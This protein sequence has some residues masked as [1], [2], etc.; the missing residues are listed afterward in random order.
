MIAGSRPTVADSRIATNLIGKIY[1]IDLNK[2]G[3]HPGA[4]PTYYATNIDGDGFEDV[5]FFV[6]DKEQ[7]ISQWPDGESN[8]ATWVSVENT[9]KEN[10]II[11]VDAFRSKNWQGE[12]FAYF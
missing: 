10:S 3:I 1:K 2:Q 11:K 9:A 7:L 5:N 8:Y 12:K 6:N 4:V